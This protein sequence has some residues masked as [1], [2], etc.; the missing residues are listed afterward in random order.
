M[1]SHN[2]QNDPVN[3]TLSK[4]AWASSFAGLRKSGSSRVPYQRCDSSHACGIVISAPRVTP[5]SAHQ[6]LSSSSDRKSRMF[7]QV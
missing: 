5:R 1:A 7:A 4:I 6:L 3:P 2:C